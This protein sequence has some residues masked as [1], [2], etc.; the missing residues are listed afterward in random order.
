MT[1]SISNSQKSLETGE[2]R[3]WATLIVGVAYWA[4]IVRGAAGQEALSV[5]SALNGVLDNGAFAVFAW[6]LLLARCFGHP[7]RRLASRGA[8]AVTVLLGLVVLM[9]ARLVT[10]GAA[11][12]L[13]AVLFTGPGMPS[14]IRQMRAV[15]F[16]LAIE[17]LWISPLLAP[18][19]VLVGH[20][21]ARV[22][23]A[24]LRALGLQAA[25]HGNVVENASTQFSI[26]VWPYCASLFPLA[27]VGLAFVVTVLFRGGALRWSLLPWLAAAVAASI[28]LTEI[29]LVLLALDA[30][31]YR[32]WHFGPGVSVYTLV[33]LGFAVAP[34]V[35]ATR[36]PA[37]PGPPTPR[38]AA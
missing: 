21:D 37:T 1:I 23:A 10:G 14:A 29:R 4:N 31:S 24:L 16:A 26:A 36:V 2:V 6:A 27:D 12:L 9:P 20:L 5:M 38:R 18:V 35:L 25:Q 33:A 32:W 34:A 8:I 13:A 19:H 28:A 3:L 11:A 22:A 30:D 15:L 17:T 7:D